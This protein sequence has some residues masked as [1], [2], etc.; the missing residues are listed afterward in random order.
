MTEALQT[1]YALRFGPRFDS[2]GLRFRRE[3]WAPA[4]R[5]GDADEAGNELVAWTALGFPG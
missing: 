4:W 2:T 3:G 1:W 5:L